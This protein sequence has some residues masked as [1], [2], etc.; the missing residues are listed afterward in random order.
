MVI[1]S[2]KSQKHFCHGWFNF[3]Y[4]INERFSHK[5]KQKDLEKLFLMKLRIFIFSFTITKLGVGLWLWYENI[6][7]LTV[8]CDEKIMKTIEIWTELS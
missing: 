6:L 4:K 2:V 3:N 5:Y 7:V 8:I 1:P